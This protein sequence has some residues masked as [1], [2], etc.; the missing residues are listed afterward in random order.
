[1]QEIKSRADIVAL[2]GESIPLKKSGGNWKGLCP[3]HG[4]KTP[5]FMVSSPKQIYH[6]FGCGEGGNIINF[7]MKFEGLSFLEAVEK[8]AARVGVRLVKGGPPKGGSPKSQDSRRGPPAEEKEELA[9]LN[10]LAARYY[11]Q[12]L[13]HPEVGKKGRAYLEARG[14]SPETIKKFGLGLALPL[15]QGLFSTLESQKVNLGMAE[16][17]GLVRRS[18]GR[19]YDFFRDRLIFPIIAPSGRVI[20]FGG[21]TLSNDPDQAKYINSVDSPLYNKGE[22]LFGLNLAKSAIR[23]RDSIIL[24][25]GYL[26]QICLFQHGFENVVAPL[27]TAL[28]EAQVRYLSRFSENFLLLFDGD[29]AGEK[30]RER[31]LPILLKLGLPAKTIA[32]PPK[33]D[34]DSL[35]RKEG[36]EAFAK[37]LEKAVPLFEYFMEKV[38]RSLERSPQGKSQAVQ[39]LLPNLSLLTGEIEKNLYI[40]KLASFLHLE[41]SLLYKEIDRFQKKGATFAPRATDVSGAVGSGEP[42]AVGNLPPLER[43]ILQL[44]LSETPVPASVFTGIEES[45]FSNRLLQELWQRVRKIALAEEGDLSVKVTTLLDELEEDELRQLAVSLAMESP[46]LEEEIVPAL[47]DCERQVHRRRFQKELQILTQEIRLAEDKKDEKRLTE[48]ILLKNKLLQDKVL[49]GE[50]RTRAS[51]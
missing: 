36:Q 13:Q 5:S 24:V 43:M 32:L 37:R 39:T 28:T 47:K 25:E 19:S 7:L 51:W 40:Q 14:I 8:L 15:F 50:E 42:L 35:L 33:E 49:I 17:L 34:P 20:G 6:C 41:E 11:Y 2:V 46:L 21:R 10:R 27:G 48:L 3:F 1:M 31:A 45:D 38:T 9:K 22:S 44:V 12:N 29:E 18:E 30:A 16:K 23:V 4:E 26:D